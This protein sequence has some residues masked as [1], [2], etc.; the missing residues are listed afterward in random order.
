MASLISKR[1][2]RVFYEG[3]LFRQE[4]IAG[5]KNVKT[6]LFKV[7]VSSWDLTPTSPL[8][9]TRQ[10]ISEAIKKIDA[11]NKSGGMPQ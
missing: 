8:K 5:L 10:K 11:K 6:E 1:E 2:N 3:K 9:K 7:M 4:F